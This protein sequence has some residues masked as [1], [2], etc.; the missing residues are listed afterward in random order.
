[1]APTPNDGDGSIVGCATNSPLLIKNIEYHINGS[2][3]SGVHLEHTN[4]NGN[5][6]DKIYPSPIQTNR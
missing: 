3:H 6:S 5:H 1:M 2:A 4:E